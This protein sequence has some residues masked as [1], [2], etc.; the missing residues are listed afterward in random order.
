VLDA[1]AGEAQYAPLF[2]GRRYVA[3]DLGVGDADWSYKSLDAVADLV[4][5]PFR[6]GSFDGAVNIVTLEHVRE[7]GVVVKELA[8]VLRPGGSLLLVTPLQWEEHQQPHD[9]Y[10]Y[11][12]Y[13]VAYLVESAGLQVEKIEAVGGIFRLLARRMLGAGMLAP[14]LLPLFAPVALFL[15]ALD[16]LDKGRQFTLGHICV[17]RKPSC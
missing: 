8:R 12:R 7:P 13:G 16:G 11:T 5:L 2:E 17:A 14:F 3:V 10:R 9:Y 4:R 6:G 15:P 1:G